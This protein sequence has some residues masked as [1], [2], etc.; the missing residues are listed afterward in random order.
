MLKTGQAW[1][2][3]SSGSTSW[4][5]AKSNPDLDFVSPKVRSTTL[6]QRHSCGEGRPESTRWLTPDQFCAQRENSGAVC[7]KSP[8]WTREQEREA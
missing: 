4:P 3:I 8:C 1:A 6:F 5:G 2:M 7:Q